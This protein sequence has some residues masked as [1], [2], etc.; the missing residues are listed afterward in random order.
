MKRMTEQKMRVTV[1]L[2]L[3]HWPELHKIKE[4]KPDSEV[5]LLL[6]E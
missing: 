6:L 5:D 3:S 2:T 1:G 4:C